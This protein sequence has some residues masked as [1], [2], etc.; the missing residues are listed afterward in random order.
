MNL[1]A[2]RSQSPKDWAS[3]DKYLTD[4]FNEYR[5]NTA[6]FTP[7]ELDNFSTLFKDEKNR[8]I[9]QIDAGVASDLNYFIREFKSA[10]ETAAARRAKDNQRFDAQALAAEMSIFEG[11]I[12]RLVK[13][14]G[15]RTGTSATTKEIQ[16]E[17]TRTLLEGSDLQKRAAAE[18]LANMV[19]SGWPHEEVMEMNRISRQA[20]KDIDNIVYTEST[21]Q[22]EA[23]VQSGAEDLR[24]AYARCDSLASKYKYNMKQTE[25]ELSKISIS[26]DASEGYQVDV[27]D[28][29]QPDRIPQFR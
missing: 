28:E 16:K 6:R 7:W 23:K 25:N 14:D 24:K 11:R 1:V 20:A 21:R 17:Y 18:V 4:L 26:W 12:N 13:R 10:K 9:P 3:A 8:I 29:P 19:P 27:S 15:K 22:A 2:G 5:E